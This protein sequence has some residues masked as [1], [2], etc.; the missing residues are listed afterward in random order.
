M[1]LFV[2]LWVLFGTCG[3]SWVLVR[4]VNGLE[5]DGKYKR[6][7]EVRVIAKGRVE[8]ASTPRTW[9]GKFIHWAGTLIIRWDDAPI[10]WTSTPVT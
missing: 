5:V 3:Y 6:T 10:H 2:Y 9:A 8:R 1:L 4:A 7:M